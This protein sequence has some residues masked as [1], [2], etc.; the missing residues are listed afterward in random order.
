MKAIFE[1]VLVVETVLILTSNLEE[2]SLVHHTAL[3]LD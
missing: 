2:L 3:K 1:T